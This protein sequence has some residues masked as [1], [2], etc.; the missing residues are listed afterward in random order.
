MPVQVGDHFVKFA[1]D[2]YGDVTSLSCEAL[3]IHRKDWEHLYDVRKSSIRLD[4]GNIQREGE[5]VVMTDIVFR[6]NP[7]E[8]NLISKLENLLQAEILIIPT[9][10][11][12]CIGHSDGVLHFVP[13]TKKVLAQSYRMTGDK[14]LAKYFD[15]VNNVLAKK[16]DIF[17]MPCSY[18][19]TPKISKR[20]FRKQY[21]ESDVFLPA[22]GLYV[23]FLI[24]GKT[25]FFPQFNCPE[26]AEA[27][28]VAETHFPGYKI[29]TV[30]CR[31][32]SM[33]GGVLN[34]VAMNYKL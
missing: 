33:E 9:E 31:R 27:M 24:V 1:Y 19:R 30:D 20:D 3:A 18:H 12:C 10:P 11:G 34:C 8:K 21:P 25:V 5:T 13:G 15:A 4:G 28:S 26:D 29:T 6:H 14:K 2:G 32:L 7:R 23:N 16:F 22:F 17:T